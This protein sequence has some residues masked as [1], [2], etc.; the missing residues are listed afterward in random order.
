MK[1]SLSALIALAFAASAVSQSC[2]DRNDCPG[3]DVCCSGTHS[4]ETRSGVFAHRRSAH[5]VQLNSGQIL[6]NCIALSQCNGVRIV[7]FLQSPG[8]DVDDLR[9]RARVP[10]V[11]A[12][13]TDELDDMLQHSY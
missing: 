3:S 1:L 11:V 6:R 5:A 13:A 7:A 8:T 12:A 9:A 2:N 4:H 10:T